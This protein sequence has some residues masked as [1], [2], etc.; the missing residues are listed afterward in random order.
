MK[1]PNSNE[2]YYNKDLWNIAQRVKPVNYQTLIILE[3]PK[4]KRHSY[5]NLIPKLHITP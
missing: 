1:D 3:I 5:I 4:S 2:A